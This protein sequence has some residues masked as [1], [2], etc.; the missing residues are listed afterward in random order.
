MAVLSESGKTS[1]QAA[2]GRF[3]RQYGAAQKTQ[4]TLIKGILR[5]NAGTVFGKEHGFGKIRTIQDY[6]RKVP[7]RNWAEISPYV[8]AV[9]ERPAR[10]VSRR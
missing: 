8:D 4:Q 9:I 2:L 6:Q 10:P 5:R 3:M 1:L 7:I